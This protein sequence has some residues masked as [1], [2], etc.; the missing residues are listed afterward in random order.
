ML[1][2]VGTGCNCTDLLSCNGHGSCVTDPYVIV[3]SGEP[4]LSMSEEEC[5]QYKIDNGYSHYWTQDTAGRPKGC[6]LY[7]DSQVYWNYHDTGSGICPASGQKC[8]QKNPLLGQCLCEGNYDGKNC[9]KCKPNWYGSK[10]QFYCDSEADYDN[11]DTKVGCHGRG[12]CTVINLDTVF[13][14]VV[15]EC[16]T[17]EVRIRINGRMQNFFSSFSPDLNCK[18]CFDGYFPKLDIFNTYDTTLDGLYVPCQVPCVPSTCNELGICNDK[19]GAPDE[20]LCI[21]EKEKTG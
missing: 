2:W 11:D 17:T 9:L 21:C 4:D 16:D 19:F 13:E 7:L 15:C 1:D 20:T 6:W 18:D 10:C 12:T 14:N 3:N 8:I 5:E